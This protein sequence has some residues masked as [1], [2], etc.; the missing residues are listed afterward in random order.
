MSTK[1]LKSKTSEKTLEN[2]WFLVFENIRNM[3]SSPSAVLD[4][5]EGRTT[6]LFSRITNFMMILD[7]MM[8]TLGF[9]TIRISIRMSG[10]SFQRTVETG[11][12]TIQT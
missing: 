1:N 12:Q 2:L 4:T 10:I 6:A 11:T 7:N 9:V 5:I 8:T 3:D